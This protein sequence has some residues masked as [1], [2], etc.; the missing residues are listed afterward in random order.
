MKRLVMILALASAACLPPASAGAAPLKLEK[1]EIKET[2]RAY[3]IKLAYPRT[4]HPAIDRQLSAWARELAT[5]FAKDAIETKDNMTWDEELTYE[6]PRNDGQVL[7]LVFTLYNF[8]GG[9]HPNSSYR[10]FHF[11]LPDGTNAE[12]AEIFS[13]RGIRRISDISIARLRRDLSGPDGMSDADWIS[14]GAAPNARN[15]ANFVLTPSELT[16]HFDSYQVAAYAAGPQE[17]RIP[18][19]QLRDTMRPDVRAPAASFDCNLARSDIEQV[20]CSSRDLARLDRRLAE[21]YADKLIWAEDDAKRQG[22]RQQQRAWLRLRDAS[23]RT[24]RINAVACLMPVY[25]QRIKELEAL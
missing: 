19:A 20:I 9:A 11:L 25:Q 22:L 7:S 2:K 15:F 5:S 24:V 10:T 13:P 21:A 3:E 1:Q 17:V 18:L 23:C 6:V 8:T 4:G 12:I 16:I 14:K